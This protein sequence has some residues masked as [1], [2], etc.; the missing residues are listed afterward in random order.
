MPFTPPRARS[1]LMDSVS[2]TSASLSDVQSL[3]DSTMDAAASSLETQFGVA[4]WQLSFPMELEDAKALGASGGRGLLDVAIKRL[5][6]ALVPF[7]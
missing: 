7:F 5:I 3:E 4:M 6:V 2:L 1:S